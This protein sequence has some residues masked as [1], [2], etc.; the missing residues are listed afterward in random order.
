[1]AYTENLPPSNLPLAASLDAWQ[2][3]ASTAYFGMQM[4]SRKGKPFE[5][6]QAYDKKVRWTFF[7]EHKSALLSIRLSNHI[8]NYNVVDFTD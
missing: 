2:L 5:S 4:A 1:M 7:S 6:C 8:F 3:A